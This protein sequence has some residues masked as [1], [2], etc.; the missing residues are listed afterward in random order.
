[1]I[2]GEARSHKS[3][4]KR[5]KK[6][7][8]QIRNIR[9]NQFMTMRGHKA[10]LVPFPHGLHP[11]PHSPPHTLWW[12]NIP[13]DATHLMAHPDVP[14]APEGL[15]PGEEEAVEVQ[16]QK[17][18]VKDDDKGKEKEKEKDKEGVREQKGSETGKAKE[19]VVED[20]E[21]TKSASSSSSRSPDQEK[22]RALA[23][24]K[25]AKDAEAAKAAATAPSRSKEPEKEKAASSGTSKDR[26]PRIPAPPVMIAGPRQPTPRERQ[27]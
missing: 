11:P 13:K 10:A 19:K 9:H 22:A 14:K 26:S 25:A 8:R 4:L 16:K 27:L 21:K 5:P 15:K 3:V 7:H 23:K 17:E 1:L 20:K 6:G 18:E 12:R 2:Q 24:A